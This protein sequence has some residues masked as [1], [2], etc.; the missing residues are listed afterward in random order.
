[1]ESVRAAQDIVVMENR[2]QAIEGEWFFLK[3]NPGTQASEAQVRSAVEVTNKTG[4]LVSVLKAGTRTGVHLLA[5][6]RDIIAVN[7]GDPFRFECPQDPSRKQHSVPFP[8]LSRP[9]GTSHKCDIRS[10]RGP[11]SAGARRNTRE[12]CVLISLCS[13]SDTRL[14]GNKPDITH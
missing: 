1:M 7:A 9:G 5:A 3:R 2:A 14:Q 10:L 11:G 8:G 6:Q 4:L 13:D 12:G